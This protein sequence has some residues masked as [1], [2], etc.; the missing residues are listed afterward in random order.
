MN[1]FQMLENVPALVRLFFKNFVLYVC[2]IFIFIFFCI[3]FKAKV[4][5][6]YCLKT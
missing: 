3:Q 4:C 1:L 5:Y 2:T 6:S